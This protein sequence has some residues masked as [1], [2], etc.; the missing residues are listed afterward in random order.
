[1]S[2]KKPLLEGELSRD[3]RLSEQTDNF[4]LPDDGT[5]PTISESAMTGPDRQFQSPMTG[6]HSAETRPQFSRAAKH[7]KCFFLTTFVGR[8]G[9]R[10]AGRRPLYPFRCKQ[11]LCSQ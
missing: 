9:P 2:F 5:R 4:R 3:E 10:A 11:T 6:P 7:N 8:S 1:M